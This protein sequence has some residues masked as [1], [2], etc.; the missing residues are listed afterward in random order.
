MACCGNS[1]LPAAAPPFPPPPALSNGCHRSSW[2]CQCLLGVDTW[3]NTLNDCV[4][5]INCTGTLSCTPSN[6]VIEL[7]NGCIGGDP[8]PAAVAPWCSPVCCGVVSPITPPPTL[9]PVFP[10][11]GP[12]TYPPPETPPPGSDT[13]TF[14]P[15]Y[16]VYTTPPGDFTTTFPPTYPVYLTTPP[17]A[18]YCKFTYTAVCSGEYW[19]LDSSVADGC[20]ADCISDPGWQPGVDDCTKTFTFCGDAC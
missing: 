3:V 10:P 9:P 1:D 14:P 4:S 2:E 20:T 13:T 7:L 5:N 17:A 18:S 11:G 6:A 12:P 15:T 19:D 8:V 16:D